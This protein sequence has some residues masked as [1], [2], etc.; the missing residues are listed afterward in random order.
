MYGKY[1]TLCAYLYQNV[2]YWDFCASNHVPLSNVE[3]LC[4]ILDSDSL[5]RYG[6]VI[7]EQ[8]DKKGL[9]PT[10]QAFEKEPEWKCLD[11]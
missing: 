8:L 9:F 2:V 3:A 4:L 1:A 5:L 11:N 10:F 7:F 6:P